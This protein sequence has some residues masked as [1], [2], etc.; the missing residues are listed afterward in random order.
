M[1]TYYIDYANGNDSNGGTGWGDAWKTLTTGATAAR[2]TP[3]D[4]IKIAKSP[5]PYSIGN[6]TWTNKSLTVTLA[7]AQNAVVT[8]CDS[9]WTAANGASCATDATNQKENSVSAKTTFPVSSATNTKY[10]Y[11]QLPSTL[12]L[13][14]YQ[15][16]S[17]WMQANNQAIAGR[18]KICLC[19]DASGNTI[20]DTFEFAEDCGITGMVPYV[21]ARTGGG[22]LGSSINS[23]ALYSA[24]SAPYDNHIIYLDNIIACT[25][26]GLNLTSLISKNTSNP[27]KPEDSAWY[28]IKSINGTDIKIDNNNVVAT[29]VGQGY[30]GTTETVATYARET[31]K[32]PMASSTSTAVQD[33]TE[34]GT[35]NARYTYSGGY[36]TSTGEQDGLTFY[37]GLNGMGYGINIAHYYCDF[38]HI[39][40]VRYDTGFRVST[41]YAGQ[42]SYIY[43]CGCRTYG[44]YSNAATLPIYNYLYI[45]NNGYAASTCYN[46]YILAGDVQKLNNVFTGNCYATS[47]AYGLNSRAKVIGD[48]IKSVNNTR[49]YQYA[50]GKINKLYTADNTYGCYLAANYG[51]EDLVL[52]NSTI[53]EATEFGASVTN[54][55]KI[56]SNNHDNTADNHYIYFGSGWGTIQSQTTTRHTA[57]GI[58]WEFKPLNNSIIELLPL[59][60]SI[61]KIAVV[62]NKLVTVKA[63]MRRSNTGLTMRLIC[64]G[65]QL[66]GV[67]E[68]YS[69]MT[70]AADTWEEV[71]ITFTPTEAG[72]VEIHAQGWGGT[73][74]SGYVDDMTITQAD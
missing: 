70:A 3:G 52:T 6:A 33:T 55:Y 23:I 73:T 16:L 48:N 38:D 10:A 37:D 35:Y 27:D 18:F 39:G 40:T 74:Y 59:E 32:T 63:W 15:R 45:N 60:L 57:S 9:A 54:S 64:K 25:T 26:T 19:S 68:T 65:N 58:A 12:N 31:Y 8:M 29:G 36:N 13:S 44:L 53:N 71:T 61:A 69:D 2:I 1:A 43:S 22:N 50:T 11:F 41:Y 20:V 5:D 17:F 46:I 51:L 30:W 66:T 34:N 28:P 62:A 67:T 72:V 21:I 49:G 4:T 47:A 14:S 24:G 42:Y 7:G 56:Y